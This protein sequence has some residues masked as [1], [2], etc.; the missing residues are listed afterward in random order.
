[1]LKGKR[2]IVTGA[3]TGIG[4]QMAYHLARMGSH[5]LITARTEARLQKVNGKLSA[6][7]CVFMA[8]H[9]H[10]G[11]PISPHRYLHMDL[12]WHKHQTGTVPSTG[13]HTRAVWSSCKHR[14]PSLQIRACCIAHTMIFELGY[15]HT[16]PFTQAPW[17]HTHP[18]STAVIYSSCSP[19]THA[20]PAQAALIK[21]Q[22]ALGNTFTKEIVF[23]APFEA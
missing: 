15:V 2:V 23:Q 5:I 11:R 17:A 9:T 4:E 1:M 7:T 20:I 21:S 8:L 12:P 13:V 3:S 18:H 19:Y 16:S 22:T 6:H 14:N 10:L